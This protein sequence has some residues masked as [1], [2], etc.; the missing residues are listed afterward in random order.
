MRLSRLALLKA[1]LINESKLLQRNGIVCLAT[2]SLQSETAMHGPRCNTS[3]CPWVANGRTQHAYGSG[4]YTEMYKV[5][6]YC[7]RTSKNRCFPLQ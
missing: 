1:I 5:T 4:S 3:N 7:L 6:T 2:T